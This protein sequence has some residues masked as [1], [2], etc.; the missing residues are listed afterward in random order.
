MARQT[1]SDVVAA[2]VREVREK[3]RIT[4]VDLAGRCA[5][6][7]EP[8][9]TVQAL[10]KLEGRRE[11]PK[12]R[13]P[14]PVTVDELITLAIALNVAPVHLLVPPDDSDAPY[15]LTSKIT[16]RR[17]PV[18]GWIRGIGPID[19]DADRREFYTE[20]PEGEFYTPAH[21]DNSGEFIGA[22]QQGPPLR[23]ESDSS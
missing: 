19:P 11:S 12:S 9:L 16:A 6:L 23:K 4:A 2:R 8:Q 14:R 21:I 13:R 3:R 15:Q 17:F 22:V 20:V 18:R 7:G 5:A 1:V 10:Y